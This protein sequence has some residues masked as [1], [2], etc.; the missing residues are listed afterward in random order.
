[1]AEELLLFKGG[2]IPC[3]GLRIRNP[4]INELETFCKD[5]G[6]E[7]IESFYERGIQLLTAYPYDYMVMLSDMGLDFENVDKFELFIYLYIF[8]MNDKEFPLDSFF[9][10]IFMNEYKFR[11]IEQDGAAV[12]ADLEKGFVFTKKVHSGAHSV[13]SEI[14]GLNDRSGDVQFGHKALKDEYIKKARKKLKKKQKRKKSA[15]LI[16]GKMIPLIKLYNGAISLD[17]IYDLNMYTMTALSKAGVNKEH[18][19]N[20]MRGV[21][22]GTVDAKKIDESVYRWYETK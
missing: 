1:M 22:S 21:Y 9:D 12:I 11:F 5:R 10:F 20:V 7:G 18:Y 2:A 3:N 14:H 13:L 15:G 19:D 8:S 4:T 6:I 16:S 17:G